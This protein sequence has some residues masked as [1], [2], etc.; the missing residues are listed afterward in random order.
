MATHSIT[1]VALLATTTGSRAASGSTGNVAEGRQTVAAAVIEEQTRE[2]E[3]T[4]E[5][6]EKAVSHLKEY[7]QSMKRD[8]DFSVDDKTGRFVVKVYDSETKELIRQI[9]S[10][11]MLAI[12]RHLVEAMEDAEA[13]KGFLIELNA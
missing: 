3:V 13:R 7:V 4:K 8:M 9:P 1:N 6:L 5:D 10:E 11:E 2:T 12:S